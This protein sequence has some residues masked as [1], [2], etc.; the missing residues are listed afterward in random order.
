MF[1]I[2]GALLVPPDGAPSTAKRHS[3]P[4]ARAQ[5]W[6]C[7]RERTQKRAADPPRGHPRF[8]PLWN[9]P[10]AIITPKAR[11][12]VNE[13]NGDV[14]SVDNR[15]VRERLPVRISQFLEA[16]QLVRLE[17]RQTRT[18][19][20]LTPRQGL[21]ETSESHQIGARKRE[22]GCEQS[23]R[24]QVSRSNANLCT[25][26]W[27]S[28][29]RIVSVAYFYDVAML[30]RYLAGVFNIAQIEISGRINCKRISHLPPHSTRVDG[31][32]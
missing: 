27:T 29:G 1:P 31:F 20:M 18:K 22:N 30:G 10:W 5:S 23:K 7:Q 16:T 3:H 32:L 21:R 11:A 12:R 28:E 15:R 4:S 17:W 26:S 13:C 9:E 24:D 8:L 6:A 19:A 2:R 25:T 14:S